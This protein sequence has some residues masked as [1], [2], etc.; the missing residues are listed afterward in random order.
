MSEKTILEKLEEAYGGEALPNLGLG[1]GGVRNREELE[2]DLYDAL[3]IINGVTDEDLD[4]GDDYPGDASKAKTKAQSPQ[5][6]LARLLSIAFTA[7]IP[8]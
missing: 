6:A 7:R 8:S 4:F 3:K 1:A 2:K 5:E